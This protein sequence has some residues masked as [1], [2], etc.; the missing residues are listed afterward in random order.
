MFL[1]PEEFILKNSFWNNVDNKSASGEASQSK[2]PILTSG[3]LQDAIF[4]SA[5]FSSIAT[6][7]RGVIQ[8]FNVGAE[9][10]LGYKADEVVDIITP[11]DISD[12]EELIKGAFELFPPR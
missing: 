11:A 4:N 10:M 9:C 8:I 2:K 7:D 12:A 1:L 3:A 6:D 5:N